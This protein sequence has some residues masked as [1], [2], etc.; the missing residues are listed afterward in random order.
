MTSLNKSVFFYS[1][2]DKIRAYYT[3][4]RAPEIPPSE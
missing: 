4:Q 3:K 2:P 1:E